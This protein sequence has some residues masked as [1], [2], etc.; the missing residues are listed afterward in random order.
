MSFECVH[1]AQSSSSDQWPTDTRSVSVMSV[2]D[3]PDDAVALRPHLSL[4]VTV[5]HGVM[6]AARRDSMA[7]HPSAVRQD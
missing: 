6:T 3:D 1:P 5:G 7:R 2:D 4:V